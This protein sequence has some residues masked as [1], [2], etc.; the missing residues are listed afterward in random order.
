[1]IECRL[2]KTSRADRMAAQTIR[3]RLPDGSAR[4]GPRRARQRINGAGEVRNGALR[5]NDKS[6]L[7]DLLRRGLMP[8]R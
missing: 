5:A 1:M 4:N 6:E 3:T 8:H 2:D 7:H